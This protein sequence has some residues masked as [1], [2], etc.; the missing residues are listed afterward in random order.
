MKRILAFLMTAAFA[1]ALVP[2]S[3]ALAQEPKV[4]ISSAGAPSSDLPVAEYKAFDQ[5]SSKH[6]EI[7]RALTHNPRLIN[8]EK[9]R[10]SHPALGAFIK[11]HPNFPEVFASNPGNFVPVSAYHRAPMHHE[12]KE[13]MKHHERMEHGKMMEHGKEM[14]HGKMMEH[15][16]KTENKMKAMSKAAPAKPEGVKA[17][18]GEMKPEK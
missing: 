7:T 17:A 12:H 16:M 15:G 2:M 1:I 5:F 11:D 8:S 18:G 4:E 3:S 14:E 13:M 6:P 10:A 9:F